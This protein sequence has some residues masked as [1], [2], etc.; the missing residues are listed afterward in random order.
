MIRLIIG[1]PGAGKGIYSVQSVVV[2]E[3]ASTRRH[4]VTN[5]ALKLEPWVRPLG[6][7]RSRAEKGLLAHLRDT[8][9]GKDFEAAKRIHLLD[10]E[11]F[12]E[13][14]LWRVDNETGELFKVDAQRDKEGRV[15]S[16]DKQ[17]LSR[18]A[19]VCYLM[20]EGWKFLWS[21]AWQDTSKGVLSYNAQHRHLGDDLWI[22]VQS[23]NQVEKAV[24]DLVQEYHTLVN[25]RYRKILFFKQPNIISVFSSN[26]PPK[27]RAGKLTSPK[28]IKFDKEGIG[29]CY[30]TAGAIG[31]S[32]AA[33]DIETKTKGL[34]WWGLLVLVLGVGLGLIGMSRALGYG[35]GSAIER[36]MGGAV[37]KHTNT[38]NVVTNHPINKLEPG[39]TQRWLQGIREERGQVDSRESVYAYRERPRPV[40][41]TGLMTLP[42]QMRA[43]LSDGRCLRPGD[44]HLQVILRDAVIVDGVR[45]EFGPLRSVD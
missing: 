29:G 44:G 14:Y 4:I 40:Y 24:R 8:Y 36:G 41:L 25:H 31:V 19:P 16:F 13:F 45:Y 6:R 30:D 11:N 2:P 17:Q 3:L 32:G 33:G 5:L 9:G 34:P 21:R 27:N 10:D 38:V 7:E 12:R 28:I 26:D 20:D 23:E 39:D 35:V 1:V 42:G 37:A 18:S 43:Y 22:A 15:L